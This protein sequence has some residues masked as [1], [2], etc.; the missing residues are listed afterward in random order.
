MI[1]DYL[2]LTDVCLACFTQKAFWTGTL[3]QLVVDLDASS[4]IIARLFFTNVFSFST[5]VR[6]KHCINVFASIY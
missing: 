4:M 5:P 3:P 2:L 1:N 6:Y